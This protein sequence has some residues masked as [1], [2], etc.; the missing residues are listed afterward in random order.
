[1]SICRLLG[2]EH[3]P[4]QQDAGAW[5]TGFGLSLLNL[6]IVGIY[7]SGYAQPRIIVVGN[8]FYYGRMSSATNLNC[9]GV[10]GIKVS[11][12][13]GDKAS[14]PANQVKA[15]NL[16]FRFNSA[17]NTASVYS[18]T[19]FG[20][21]ESAPAG[22]DG[23][24]T[25][26]GLQLTTSGLIWRYGTSS[27]WYNYVPKITYGSY[28]EFVIKNNANQIAVDVYVDGSLAYENINTGSM[29]F[30]NWYNNGYFILG[31][32]Y[33]SGQ[34]NLSEPTTAAQNFFGFSDVYV[35]MDDGTPDDP[36]AGR[37]GPIILQRIPASVAVGDDWTPSSGSLL[38]I[39][40]TPRQS[41]NVSTPTIASGPNELPMEITFDASAIPGNI[42]ALQV[43]TS[44]LRPS[45]V[46]G[47]LNLQLKQGSDV[48][49]DKTN[50]TLPTAAPHLETT[51]QPLQ[52]L[53]GALLTPA[54]IAN[55]TLS[56]RPV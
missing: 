23:S 55:L 50:A 46:A 43:S 12:L 5:N 24:Y 18:C 52:Q 4:N 7:N 33:A 54:D 13:L 17:T 35:T 6:G 31:N 22:A 47:N 53:D 36:Y 48:L 11:A 2:V 32:G 37:L 9:R 42:A 20:L 29:D 49:L 40:N 38:D 3:L 27:G 19:L 51:L 21:K 44:A 16:G 26:N 25:Y 14:V 56:I 41:P 34:G 30:T 45:G 1:M 28:V 10:H 15:I 39:I 8:K